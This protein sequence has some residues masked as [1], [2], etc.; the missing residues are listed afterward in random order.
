MEPPLQF[1]TFYR[2]GNESM[3]ELRGTDTDGVGIYVLYFADGTQY[4]GKTDYLNGR[5]GDHTREWQKPIVRVDF[6]EAPY[7]RTALHEVVTIFQRQA[8]GARLENNL[9]NKVVPVRPNGAPVRDVEAVEGIRWAL[10]ASEDEV[11]QRPQRPRT[12]SGA[13]LQPSTARNIL[14][15]LG[16]DVLRVLTHYVGQVLRCPVDTEWTYWRVWTPTKPHPSGARSWARLSVRNHDMLEIV[17]YDD[18]SLYVQAMLDRHSPID[19]A[20][21]AEVGHLKGLTRAVQYTTLDHESFCR[22]LLEDPDY[23]AAARTFAHDMML[24]GPCTKKDIPH[25]WDLADVIFAV[26]PSTTGKAP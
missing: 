2:P 11:R 22:A 23:L 19:P 18:G 6:A 4:V 3:G 5:I 26:L 25:H 10:L 1:T 21:E 24:T 17:Q 20:Y 9:Y 13:P 7:G 8:E 14:A 16:V 12:P 15:P